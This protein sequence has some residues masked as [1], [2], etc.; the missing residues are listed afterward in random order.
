VLATTLPGAV[1]LHEGQFEG[2]KVRLPVF[3]G[4]RPDEPVDKDLL[5]FYL[6]LLPTVAREPFRSGEWG[7][8]EVEGWPD[9]R[10]CDNLAA[11]CW[12][13]GKERRLVVVNLADA[14]SQGKLRVPWDNLP[15][16]SWRLEELLNYGDFVRSGDE[17]HGPG[18]YVEL[19]P[20][21]Y[22]LLSCI[23]G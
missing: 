13:D 16:R 11:W 21:G 19:P 8:C 4:R 17:M 7:L 12:H 14:P 9:N 10:S 20:W 15:G 5:E 1:L 3:L 18:M 6:R 23:P 22:H 2:R